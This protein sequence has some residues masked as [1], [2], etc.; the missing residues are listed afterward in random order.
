[1]VRLRCHPASKIQLLLAAFPLLLILLSV[2]RTVSS[3]RTDRSKFPRLAALTSLGMRFTN[4]IPSFGT[5]LYVT[6]EHAAPTLSCAFDSS[7]LSVPTN[8]SSRLFLL[9]TFSSL[10]FFALVCFTQCLLQLVRAS[11][12]VSLAGSAPPHA[13]PVHVHLQG[14]LRG[15]Q[16]R[17]SPGQ[18]LPLHHAGKL[19]GPLGRPR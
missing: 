14:T 9:Q 4:M 13:G 3:M 16:G 15:R 11:E 2:F 8:V 7:F 1:M 6:I 18:Y 5:S 17:L 12:R 19:R 10:P